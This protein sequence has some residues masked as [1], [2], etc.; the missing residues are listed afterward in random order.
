M[1]LPKAKVR[2]SAGRLSLSEEGQA[3]CFAAG[4]NFVFSVDTLLTTPNPE[5]N[6]DAKLFVKLG[7]TPTAPVLVHG[8]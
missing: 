7:L 2:L 1:H 3:L 6:T 4:A 8:A 5:A